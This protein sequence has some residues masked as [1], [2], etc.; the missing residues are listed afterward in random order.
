MAHHIT[1]PSMTVAIARGRLSVFAERSAFP[2]AT[3]MV[4]TRFAQ[5]LLI[6]STLKS[7]HRSVMT[8]SS[9]SSC[10]VGHRRYLTDRLQFRSKRDLKSTFTRNTSST[11]ES[12]PTHPEHHPLR[13]SQTRSRA[14]P[15]A[16]TFCTSQ[17]TPTTHFSVRYK[18][19]VSEPSPR[20]SHT[21]SEILSSPK[22]F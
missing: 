11:P 2:H 3:R 14:S 10:L 21:H 20:S 5:P 8:R 16:Q 7:Y 13:P 17:N 1:K 12:S 9:S 22:G 19:R 15:K 4:R 18:P 6:A